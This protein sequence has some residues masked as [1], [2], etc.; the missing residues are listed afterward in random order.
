MSQGNRTI[1]WFLFGLL[2][3]TAVGFSARDAGKPDGQK[4]SYLGREVR[5]DQPVPAPARDALAG[6]AEA[7]QRF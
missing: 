3:V 1:L 4:G 7:G 5:Q 6:R 2:L